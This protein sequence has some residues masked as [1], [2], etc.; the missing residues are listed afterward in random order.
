MLRLLGR[1]RDGGFGLNLSG[2]IDLYL[3][4]GLLKDRNIGA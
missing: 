3:C 1:R 4:M 2:G